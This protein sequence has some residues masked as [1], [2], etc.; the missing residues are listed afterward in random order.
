[1]QAKKQ[2][3]YDRCAARTDTVAH[4]SMQAKK[5][6]LYDRTYPCVLASRLHT[7]VR[8]NGMQYYARH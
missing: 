4:Y 8:A 6:T 3:L 7:S 1:M 5:Q 2:T